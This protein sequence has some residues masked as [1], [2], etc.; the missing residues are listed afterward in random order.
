MLLQ[1]AG[2]SKSYA[3]VHALKSVSFE[4]N[5]G[6]VHALV[7]ENGAGK[8]TLIKILTG[9]VQPDAGQ[10][11]LNGA[12]VVDNNPH[13]ARSLGISAIYQQPSLFPHL[14]VAENIA[15]ATE[16]PGMFRRIDWPGR[17]ARCRELLARAGS[18]I[19][20]D[21]EVSSLSMPEQQVVE[22]AKALGTQAKVLILDEPT[23][24]L[25]MREV[26]RLFQV[27]RDLRAEGVG[28]IYIS[29]RLDE[30]PQIADR[31]TVL[32][33]GHAITTRAMAGITQPELIAMMVG[34]A[35]VAVFPKRPVPVGKVALE[36]R[37]RVN[38]AVRAGEILG[39]AGLVGAG[40][41]ELAEAI[42]GLRPP[43]DD[44][45][46][47]IREQRVRILHPAQAIA[48]GLAYVPEDRR[49]HGLIMEMPIAA[50]TTL[51]NL[52]AI[53]RHGFLDFAAE[54]HMALDYQARL[55]VKAESIDVPVETLSGGNQQ[56]VVLARWLATNPAVLILDEP[57][58]GVD[59][60]AKSEI[61]GIMMELAAR[62]VAIVMIS[63]ELPEILGMSDR[64]AVMREGRVAG[65]LNRAQANPAGIMNLALGTAA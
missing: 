15:L 19:D 56:K 53:S 47:L 27:I 14:T 25:T 24:S 13:L 18:S 62:G 12:P 22:I 6:E 10:I 11:F 65:I 45:E 46:I 36:V 20:P 7:G 30:L 40:R 23:A 8:S 2:L 57:T 26:D 9:A 44:L 34:R 42:F 3:G 28:M 4:L 35:L 16:K 39:I 52:P 49:Q 21:V 61:H 41:T 59:V 31:V 60:G 64:V 1:A 37:G 29:H 55:A 5:A 32:R 54:R 38:L 17:R 48:L 58:Q 50:N 33:D 51:A 43:G 63:S